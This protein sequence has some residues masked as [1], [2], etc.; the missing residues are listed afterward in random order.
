M[1]VICLGRTASLALL[2]SLTACSPAPSP[3]AQSLPPSS[4]PVVP[5]SASITP[6]P[7][8]TTYR[9]DVQLSDTARA[10]VT[11]ND[12][13][14]LVRGVTG[15]APAAARLTEDELR[16]LDQQNAIALA[17]SGSNDVNLVWRTGVCWPA[18]HVTIRGSAA[19]LVIEVDEGPMASGPCDLFGTGVLLR[20]AMAVPIDLPAVS[21]SLAGT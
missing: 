3:A 12:T 13:S 2:A 7:T 9:L 1:A 15:V 18:Q 10:T 16:Q 5:P 17:I 20:L 8:G 21:V 19:R 14:G 6:A 4:S 11:L